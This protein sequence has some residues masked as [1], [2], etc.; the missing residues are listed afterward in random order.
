MCIN[1]FSHRIRALLQA[2][3]RFAR[4]ADQRRRF[5]R[6]EAELL[7]QRVGRAVTGDGETNDQRQIA[8]AVGFGEDLFQFVFSIEREGLHAEVVVGARDG[9]GGTRDLRGNKHHK[10][11]CRA[12]G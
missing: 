7:R 4:T 5:V 2:V 1:R 8:R 6:R 10:Y 11:V 3:G 12:E 9:A